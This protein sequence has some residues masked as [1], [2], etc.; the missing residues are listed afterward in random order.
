L[1]GLGSEM[2]STQTFRW[3]R[4]MGFS[5]WCP[6]FASGSSLKPLSKQW[7]GKLKPS[8]SGNHPNWF[9]ISNSS[10]LLS[11]QMPAFVS[12]DPHG[13]IVFCHPIF[14]FGGFPKNVLFW[15]KVENLTE[16]E[17]HLQ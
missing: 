11:R 14:S 17:C 1:S 7:S 6:L 13:T 15:N 8:T 9:A 16:G 12:C 3:F 5:T 10:T 4:N 2:M